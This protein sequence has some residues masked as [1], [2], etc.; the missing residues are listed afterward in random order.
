MKWKG[1]RLLAMPSPLVLPSLADFLSLS[2]VSSIVSRCTYG[3]CDIAIYLN[4]LFSSYLQPHN[5]S[6]TLAYTLLSLVV[7]GV[8]SGKT[9]GN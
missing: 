1:R 2:S 8:Y 5:N 6:A 7:M 4:H 9:F 3:F